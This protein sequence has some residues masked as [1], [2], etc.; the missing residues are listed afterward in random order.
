L[1]EVSPEAGLKPI[2]FKTLSKQRRFEV[3][4]FRL[5]DAPE[6]DCTIHLEYTEEIDKKF[7]VF[8]FQYERVFEQYKNLQKEA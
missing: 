6:R 7:R 5:A 3:R 1:Y 4:F 2:R 8:Q